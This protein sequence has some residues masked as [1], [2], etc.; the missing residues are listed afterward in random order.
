MFF[1]LVSPLVRAPLT[2]VTLMFD[3]ALFVML[4]W[5]WSNRSDKISFRYGP[6]Y[7]SPAH[8]WYLSSYP[9]LWPESDTPWVWACRLSSSI[10][11]WTPSSPPRRNLSSP[12]M[13]G[14][15]S[16]SHGEGAVMTEPSHLKR[17]ITVWVYSD[18]N[19]FW[20]F[21]FQTANTYVLNIYVFDSCLKPNFFR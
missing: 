9:W 1:G 5:L 13:L 8:P 17:N 3:V 14:V 10:S 21:L 18:W 2:S 19:N 12:L 7:P 4:E 20:N 6:Q 15:F 11:N 16:P